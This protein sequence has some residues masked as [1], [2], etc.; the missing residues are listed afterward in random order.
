[1][2]SFFSVNKL[3][4]ILKDSNVEIRKKTGVI[5]GATDSTCG[6]IFLACYR[7]LLHYFKLDEKLLLIKFFNNFKFRGTCTWF[8]YIMANVC[9]PHTLS[10]RNYKNIILV[11]TININPVIN[12]IFSV[13]TQLYDF[14]DFFYLL[15]LKNWM[16]CGSEKWCRAIKKKREN[17]C[18][19]DNIPRL[20]A[21][22]DG[23]ILATHIKNNVS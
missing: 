3:S 12:Q 18:L 6:K 7:W 23:V 19:A 15:V 17:I 1:M 21:M 14:K 20:Q 11:H 4:C 5:S 10:V 13:N 22:I 8:S 9:R 2:S 16:I